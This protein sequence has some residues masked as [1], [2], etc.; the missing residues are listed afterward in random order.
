M[1]QAQIEAVTK[2]K[3]DFAGLNKCMGEFKKSLWKVEKAEK[4]FNQQRNKYK[5]A[6][7]KLMLPGRDEDRLT[8]LESLKKGGFAR[9]FQSNKNRRPERLIVEEVEDYSVPKRTTA[10]TELND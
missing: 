10:L 4:H 1:T 3:F 9:R 8:Q 6:C 5:N 7:F 2:Y